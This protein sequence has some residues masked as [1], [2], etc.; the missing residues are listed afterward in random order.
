LG[1]KRLELVL[2][3]G[4]VQKQRVKGNVRVYRYIREDRRVFG[5]KEKVV[6]QDSSHP[7]H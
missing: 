2:L 4:L 3:Y 6:E 7:A 5:V 1:P